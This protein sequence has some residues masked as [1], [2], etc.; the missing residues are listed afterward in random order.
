[1]LEHH[2]A[3]EPPDDSQD[4]DA[5]L[6]DLWRRLAAQNWDAPLIV[7]TTVQL[8]ESLFSNRPG[9]CGKLHRLAGSVIVLNEVQ[10]LPT[11]LL[12][13]LLSG[14]R[15]LTENFDV[16]VVLCTATQPAFAGESPVLK[17]FPT[18]TP[19]IADPAPH[20]AALRRVT[21]RVETDTPWNWARVAGEM[22][23]AQKNKWSSLCIVNTRRQALFSLG[24]YHHKAAKRKDIAERPAA[25]KQAGTLALDLSE[26][27]ADAL[28]A[29]EPADTGKSDAA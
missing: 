17:G 23:T 4:P 7:T 3:I 6:A 21:Y 24:Y 5:A 10:T 9:K 11:H 2:S 25:K 13:P 12:T 16:T 18:V 15:T 27:L 8:F 29:S 14:L 19:V 28:A 1:M 26:S 20:F 22:R